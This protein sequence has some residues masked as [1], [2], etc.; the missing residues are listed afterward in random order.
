MLGQAK[1]HTSSGDTH[2]LCTQ[3][4]EHQVPCHNPGLRETAPCRYQ[5]CLSVVGCRLNRRK[6]WCSG[7]LLLACSVELALNAVKLPWFMLEQATQHHRH[8]S[9]MFHVTTQ[10]C[11]KQ[12]ATLRTVFLVRK[13]V[14]QRL[15]ACENPSQRFWAGCTW[16]MD[17]SGANEDT[18]PLF[19]I[20]ILNAESMYLLSWKW[21][22]LDADYSEGP[23]PLKQ[24]LA[25]ELCGNLHSHDPG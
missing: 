5:P 13:I 20:W 8:L 19:V 11:G 10:H 9:T 14:P 2:D 4:F 24:F 7:L 12:H 15:A 6:R 3:T 16:S 17:R 25:P 1:E 21:L 22:M 18:Y 23:P